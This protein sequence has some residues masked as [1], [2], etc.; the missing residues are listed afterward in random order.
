MLCGID[1]ILWNILAFNLY[2]GI[3]CRIMLVSQ[4]IVMDLNNVVEGKP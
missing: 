4:S 2:D 3:F 1:N